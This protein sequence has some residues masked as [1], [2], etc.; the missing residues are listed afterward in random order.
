ME[1]SH[2]IELISDQFQGHDFVFAI[3][4]DDGNIDL[5]VSDSKPVINSQGSVSMNDG[6]R[7]RTKERKRWIRYYHY[8]NFT[9]DQPLLHWRSIIYIKLETYSNITIAVAKLR[10]S[11][12]S[13][14]G[15]YAIL[16]QETAKS[17]C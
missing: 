1:H 13:I 17:L 6:R 15:Q 14:E 9:C 16:P 4:F 10:K 12:E 7:Y 11:S 5:R 2:K 8:W 3:L